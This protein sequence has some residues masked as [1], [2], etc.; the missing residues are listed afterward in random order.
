MEVFAGIEPE[1]ELLLSLPFPVH[2]DVGV[3][4]VRLPADVP[5][6]LEVDLVVGRP[7]RRQLPDGSPVR[8]RKGER[9]RERGGGRGLT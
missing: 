3:E 5:Q 7:L 4:C 8:E 6:E 1:V 2:E 9:D